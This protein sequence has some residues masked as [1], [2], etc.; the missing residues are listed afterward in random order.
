MS[1][2][3]G[4][5][6]APV[7]HHNLYLF[8]TGNT[9]IVV[10]Q[11]RLMSFVEAWANVGVGFGVNFAA[12]LVV[13]PWFGFQVKPMQAFGIGMAFTGISLARSYVLR[14]VFEGVGR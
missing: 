2:P 7:S 3:D 6:S 5:H 14:R 1:I 12:N 9:P 11:S 13:L 10:R 4:E 8:P